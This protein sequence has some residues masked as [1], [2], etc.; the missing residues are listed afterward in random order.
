MRSILETCH[1][2]LASSLSTTKC[3]VGIEGP[4]CSGG[5]PLV[6]RVPECQLAEDNVFCWVLSIL[7]CTSVR[8]VQVPDQ[9]RNKY[10][11][12]PRRHRLH[13]QVGIIESSQG[14]TCWIDL[15]NRGVASCCY[16]RKLLFARRPNIAERKRSP[17]VICG[18]GYLRYLTNLASTTVKNQNRRSPAVICAYGYLRYRR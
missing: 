1:S 17:T 6:S 8:K 10:N 2:C 4:R 3:A 16:L 5:L 15:Y 13:V 14:R 7:L 11:S 18:Y 12:Q 9:C